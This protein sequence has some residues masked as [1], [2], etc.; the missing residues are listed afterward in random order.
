MSNVRAFP[1]FEKMETADFLARQIL[2]SREYGPV[3]KENLR[4]L[5]FK[6]NQLV[7]QFLTLEQLNNNNNNKKHLKQ[8]LLLDE[9][10]LR[11]GSEQAILILN[12]SERKLEKEPIK[13]LD[14]LHKKFLYSELDFF[15]EIHF[16][17]RGH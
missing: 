2:N 4:R 13:E 1:K 16:N 11:N 8:R 10:Q 15:L 9:L 17:N 14:F 12:K 3:D 5:F 6:T 7:Y